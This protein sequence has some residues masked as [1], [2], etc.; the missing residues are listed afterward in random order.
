MAKHVRNSI[1]KKTG[2]GRGKPTRKY[3]RDRHESSGVVACRA[4]C[5]RTRGIT[6]GRPPVPPHPLHSSHGRLHK[7]AV[8]IGISINGAESRRLVPIG[9]YAG[10]GMSATFGWRIYAVRAVLR[11]WRTTRVRVYDG[12]GT[13]L[14]TWSQ[15][16]R[17][18]SGWV[19]PLDE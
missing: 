3:V 6:D 12:D 1:K 2:R 19:R 13:P 15:T 8:S 10:D 4:V 7:H 17:I 11:L 5:R 16:R 18:D 9:D 14:A